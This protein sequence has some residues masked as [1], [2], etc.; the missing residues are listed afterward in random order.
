MR[1]LDYSHGTGTQTTARWTVPAGT[2]AGLVDATGDWDWA[3]DGGKEEHEIFLRNAAWGATDIDVQMVYANGYVHTESAS[4]SANTRVYFRGKP[5]KIR[6]HC[7]LIA[8]GV[9]VAVSVQSYTAGD[10]QD[11]D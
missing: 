6:F 1:H 5:L 4:V 8:A 9:I 11:P 3:V 2:A 10:Y 7:T